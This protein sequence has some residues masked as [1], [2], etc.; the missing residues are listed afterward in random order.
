M[1]E[2]LNYP[3]E[4]KKALDA[5]HEAIRKKEK[6]EEMWRYWEKIAKEVQKIMQDW[7]LWKRYERN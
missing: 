4:Y 1:S 2:Q 5:F 3:S 6:E 7:V